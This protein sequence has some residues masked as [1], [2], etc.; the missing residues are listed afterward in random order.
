[1]IPAIRL[2][3][4]GIVSC[5]GSGL[6]PAI[7]GL[8]NG[9]GNLRPLD[10]FELPGGMPA[11]VSLIPRRLFAPGAG[12]FI[13]MCRE[14][15]DQ[16]LA[17][18]GHSTAAVLQD[19]HCALIVGSGGFLFVAEA[20]IHKQ[21]VANVPDSASIHAPSWAAHQIMT[22][23]G[24]RGRQFTLTTAC[25][26]SA[27]ALLL[28]HELLRAQ[29]CKRV[30]V[31]GAEGLCATTLSGFQSLM[32]LA[33]DGCK[34]FDTHRQGLQ[35]GEAVACLL[36]ENAPSSTIKGCYLGGGANRCDTY[37][38]TSADPSGNI[39][40]SVMRQALLRSGITTRDIDLIKIHGV[41][42]RD[43]DSAEAAA[44]RQVFGAGMPP[45][46]G[47]KRY[48]GHTLGASGALETALL[49]GC[50]A[51]NFIPATAGF[52]MIDDDL[53]MTPLRSTVTASSTRHVLM[54]FFGFGGNYTS[55]VMRH[56]A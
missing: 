27:N 11:K 45:L 43:S 1:V 39:M 29:R 30:L 14:A 49:S 51:Q 54:N 5:F 38:P 52:A 46:T 10:D 9:P 26:S 53:A 35:L 24:M 25:S 13:A 40:A 34:P 19:E 36:L 6:A 48:V 16:C 32:L 4:T 50:L 31:I 20:E 28:A 18:A 15:I 42:S 33:Q 22:A 23:Y 3:G 47:L 41:G 2:A 8:K 37:H 12:E 7:E 17:H 44:L 55:L 56:A 21:R